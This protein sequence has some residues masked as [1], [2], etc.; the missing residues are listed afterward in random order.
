[1]YDREGRG[2]VYIAAMPVVGLTEWFQRHRRVFQGNRQQYGSTSYFKSA[3]AVVQG[4]TKMYQKE[5]HSHGDLL[6]R[7]SVL[8][9][10]R[11]SCTLIH[12]PRT[13]PQ[14]NTPDPRMH[15][16]DRVSADASDP[17]IVSLRQRLLELGPAPRRQQLDHQQE[18]ALWTWAEQEVAAGRVRL[19]QTGL[20]VHAL[21]GC[22]SLLVGDLLAGNTRACSCLCGRQG[23]CMVS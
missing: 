20:G 3:V 7:L 15:V 2:R 4:Q 23:R 1:M 19:R 5:V 13:R 18:M 12:K 14:T 9:P 10:C 11:L 22:A 17:E 21:Y 8:L 6:C 16:Q